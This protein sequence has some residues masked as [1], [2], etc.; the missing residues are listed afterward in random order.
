MGR[1]ITSGEL[2]AAALVQSAIALDWPGRFECL[3]T[4]APIARMVLNDK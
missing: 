1:A 3:G 2:I 4:R